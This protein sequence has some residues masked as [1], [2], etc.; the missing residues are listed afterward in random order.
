M[1]RPRRYIYCTRIPRIGALNLS[2]YRSVARCDGV[3]QPEAAPILW[4]CRD[5]AS[6]WARVSRR[7]RLRHASGPCVS[8]CVAAP[9]FCI[10]RTC[11][12][13]L[14]SYH[15][16]PAAM[17]ARTRAPWQICRR[18]ASPARSATSASTGHR[19]PL[20]QVRRWCRSWP[21]SQMHRRRHS[22]LRA[23]CTLWRVCP[24]TTFRG[25]PPWRFSR[26]TTS[27][28]ECRE[29]GPSHRPVQTR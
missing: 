27:G 13:R 17:T 24:Y 11:K 3:P 14:S 15:K 5:S 1:C 19:Q 25:L 21:N 4:D 20:R 12:K 23:S 18:S 7:S 28:N 10:P 8:L 29:P 16:L 2:A 26:W 6:G 22:Y 9:V